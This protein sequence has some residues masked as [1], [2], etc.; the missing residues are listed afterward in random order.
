MNVF[1]PLGLRARARRR[2]TD[3]A[4]AR[5]TRVLASLICVPA[6][7]LALVQPARAYANY[8]SGHISRVSFVSTGVLIWLD[9]GTPTNCTNTPYGW[10]MISSSS[11]PMVAFVTGLWMRGDASQ[12]TVTVY[13]GGIDSTGYCQIGQID[14][15]NAGG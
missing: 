12:V 13:T 4:L 9:T 7:A 10:M 2:H 5:A 15:G 1:C 14:T 11:T 8:Q 3:F 6:I